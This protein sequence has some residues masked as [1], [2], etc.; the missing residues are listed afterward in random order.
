MTMLAIGFLW[1]STWSRAT[2]TFAGAATIDWATTAH[3]LSRHHGHEQNPL[4]NW[5]PNTPT[6]IALG[7]A[8]DV[9]AAAMWRHGTRHHPK[10]TAAGFYTGAEARAFFAVRNEYRI[11]RPGTCP[12][13]PPCSTGC[14][15]AFACP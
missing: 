8:I 4:I 10:L 6:T 12:P 14:A 5:A 11:A 13:R 15:Q 9:A 3:S 7:A 2:W 1:F